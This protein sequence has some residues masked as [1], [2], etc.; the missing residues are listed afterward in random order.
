M[1]GAAESATVP[2]QQLGRSTETSRQLVD[3]LLPAVKA[4]SA[5][6]PSAAM[7]MAEK[8]GAIRHAEVSVWVAA[9]DST[10]A[11]GAADRMFVMSW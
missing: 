10:A 11:A 6:V 1:A 9:E 5:P 3:T 2:A 8:Q 7:A 4:A